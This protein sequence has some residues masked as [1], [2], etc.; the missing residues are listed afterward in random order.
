MIFLETSFLVNLNVPTLQNH[1][2]AKEIWWDIKDKKKIISNMVV[3]ETLTVLRKL[4]Q[5]DK[6]VK[7]VYE[8]LVD[9]KIDVLDDII[10]YEQT[11]DYTFN[12]NNIGFFDNLS[13]IVM[14]NN[15]IKTIASFDLGFDIF[16]DIKRIG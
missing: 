6:T 9:G 15:D 7:K 1:K 13:Y 8:L 4:K 2:R 16:E 3:Y 12:K 5:D 11:L 14:I 10:Y